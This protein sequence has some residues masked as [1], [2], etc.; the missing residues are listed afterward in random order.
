MALALLER[1]D[2]ALAHD[3]A[4]APAPPAAGNGL[5]DHPSEPRM[6]RSDAPAA[7]D[8]FAPKRRARRQVARPRTPSDVEN[9]DGEVSLASSSLIAFVARA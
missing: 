8:T 1:V 2:R 3:D 9:F 5:E 7:S 6:A 4:A